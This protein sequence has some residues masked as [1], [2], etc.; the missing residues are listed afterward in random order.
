MF[1]RIFSFIHRTYYILSFFLFSREIIRWFVLLWEWHPFNDS[2]HPWSNY[3]GL[4]HSGHGSPGTPASQVLIGLIR[5]RRQLFEAPLEHERVVGYPTRTAC[6]RLQLP[7]S[8]FC[9]SWDARVSALL[10]QSP[11]LPRIPWVPLFLQ[12]R[13][14]SPPTVDRNIAS[15]ITS[16]PILHILQTHIL[17]KYLR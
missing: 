5:V 4:V 7:W 12:S 15:F 13:D 8:V 6:P 17:L 10:V 14:C 2:T 1:L 16:R 11:R 9:G 3:L